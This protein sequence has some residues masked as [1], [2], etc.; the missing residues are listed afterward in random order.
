[1]LYT[2]C[3]NNYNYRERMFTDLWLRNVSTSISQPSKWLTDYTVI[4]SLSRTTRSFQGSFPKWRSFSWNV[5]NILLFFTWHINQYICN[6][7]YFKFEKV[8][9][10]NDSSKF[11]KNALHSTRLLGTADVSAVFTGQ[12]IHK[13]FHVNSWLFVIICCLESAWGHRWPWTHSLFRLTMCL[14]I[15]LFFQT[16]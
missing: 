4:N 15:D 13:C 3:N 5:K 11:Y 16:Q 2:V 7:C 8:K 10:A 1:M 9:E 12:L 6:F 14:Q